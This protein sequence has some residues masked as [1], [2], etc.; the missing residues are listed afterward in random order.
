[1]RRD[2]LIAADLELA[3]GGYRL[4]WNFGPA[5]NQRI[6]HPHLHLLGGTTLSDKLA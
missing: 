5:T 4:A 1:M 2:A 3:V 6:T